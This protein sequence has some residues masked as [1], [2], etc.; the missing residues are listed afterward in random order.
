MKA[1]KNLKSIN[2]PRLWLRQSR[3]PATVAVYTT[4]NYKSYLTDSDRK[5]I[6]SHAALGDY[7][8]NYLTK[9]L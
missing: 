7:S 9:K 3:H 6:E 8:K 4:I 2:W 1:R 5:H